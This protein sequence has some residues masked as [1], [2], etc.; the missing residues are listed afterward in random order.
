M[1]GRNW[2]RTREKTGA[3]TESGRE[4]NDSQT[5]RTG[6]LILIDSSVKTI[7]RMTLVLACVKSVFFRIQTIKPPVVQILRFITPGL[8]SRCPGWRFI[9]SLGDL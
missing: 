3:P 9:P 8:S 4:K 7:Q 5:I 2:P 1:V 6:M